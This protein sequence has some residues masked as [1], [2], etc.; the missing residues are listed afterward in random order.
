M[1]RTLGVQTTKRSKF[2][3]APP[4]RRKA[5][6]QSQIRRMKQLLG[7]EPKYFDVAVGFVI[8]ATVNW[9]GSEVGA[10]MPQIAE[11]D[12][13]SSRNGRKISLTRVKFR[14]TV[15]TTALTGQTLVPGSN[16]VR[17]VLVRNL[18]PKG[19]SLNG[20]DVLGLNSGAA[21]NTS[22]A[23]HMFQS[24]V[25]FGYA[26]IVDDVIMN[27]D[28]SVAVNN[29]SATTVSAAAVE[30][31]F[32]LSYTPKKPIT[33][34]YSGSGAAIPNINSF[35][36]L[37]NAEAVQYVPTLQGVCRFYYTDA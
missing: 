11:G 17:V 2:S 4:K 34:Q 31:S 15:M 8:P 37:A 14:G 25:S 28:A 1:S 19:V 33:I 27:L 24:P 21:G 20:E 7:V 10:D 3:G 23:I 36:I 22:V 30:K 29:A 5:N 16:T 32:S 35:N 9:A 18:A 26:K 6:Q 13:I 12:D